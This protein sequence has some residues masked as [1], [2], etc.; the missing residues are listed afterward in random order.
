MERNNTT[1][2]GAP[3]VPNP[4]QTHPDY[5]VTEVRD[6]TG[7]WETVY[8]GQLEACED[9]YRTWVGIV[10]ADRVRIRQ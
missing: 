2:G 10:G 3:T 6:E 7:E 8:E 4:R 5:G 9:A 1:P